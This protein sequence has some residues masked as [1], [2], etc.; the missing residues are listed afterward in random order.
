MFFLFYILGALLDKTL[1]KKWARF[2]GLGIV[3]WGTTFPIFTNLA[4]ITLAFAIIA[5]MILLF[6]C[7]A[8]LLAFIAYGHN[9]T[10]CFVEA[11][12]NR[13]LHYPR[14]LFQTFTGLY[15]GQVCL[16][17]LFVVGKGWGCVA[18]QAIGIA[19]T[20]FCHI[21]LKEAFGRLT[22][23]L[24]IDC[25]KPLDGFS[26]TVSYQGESDFK[27]KVLDKRKNE[28]ADLLKEDQKD[29]ERVEEET[30]QLEGGQ[31][32]VPLLA[33]RDFKTTESK[34]W[35]VRFVRPDVF[36]N[37]RHAKRMIPA[38][39]NMEEEVVD[40]KH[41]FDQPAIAAQ[42]PKLWIPKDPYGW[43]QKEIESNRK[44]IEMT[45]ENSGFSEN[46]KPQFFGESPV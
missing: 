12:D 41:A 20:A 5:P 44:I 27:T 17:G 37:F 18:L 9:L 3:M 4:S 8:F 21:N 19:F 1:R 11:P 2:S 25:M 16:L 24:P 42:M 28:K 29:H 15:L 30:Q 23:V 34:N 33:D 26:K 7:V 45:D 46:C 40:D 14:A 35:L 6:G 32:L 31:N 38:T 43:S 39:Y 36:L 10:Y 13:G 22:T